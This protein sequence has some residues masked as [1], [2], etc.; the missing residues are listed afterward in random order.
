VDAETRK[1][2]GARKGAGPEE[3]SA[4]SPSPALSGPLPSIVLVGRQNA[5]KSTLFNRL[6]QDRRAL[7]SDIPGTTRDWLEGT[8]HWGDRSYRVI[9]TGGYAPGPDVI[10]SAVRAQVERWVRSADAVLWVVDGRNG[11]AP[12]EQEVGRWLRRRARRVIVAVNKMDD[13]SADAALPEFHRLGYPDVVGVSASHGRRI[14]VLLDL[15]EE[16]MGPAEAAPAQDE[17][18]I[19]VAIV[20]RPNVGKS[21]LVNALLGEERAIVSAVAG[22][23]RDAVDAPLDWE[24]RRFLFIDTAGL[25]AR[26]AKGSQ[27][28]EGLTRLMAEKA[29]DR[30]EVAVLILDAGEGLTE[31]DVAV[32]RLI[33]AKGRACVVGVNKWDLVED[34]ARFAQWYRD[35]QPADMPFFNWP[36]L[37]FLSAKTGYHAP[38]LLAAVAEARDQYHR[39]FDDEDIAAFFWSQIQ[40]RPYSHHGRKLV[41]HGAEQASSAPPVIVLRCNLPEEDV[42]F[43]Y[44]RRLENLFREK[45]KVSGT[46]VFFRFRRK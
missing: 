1:R 32:A 33:D 20:G 4:A 16:R 8:A 14:N 23:T 41:F 17:G 21:S 45:Y 38:D 34:K 46:P 31:G 43:S 42:H 40:E 6:C 2:G 25:R 12:P 19:R 37:V 10:L 11:L 28:L 3:D 36:P 15:V 29:L 22:T 35:R 39:R 27:G 30:C 24:N 7:T 18:R 26:K 9:D 13:A 5:G 44:R